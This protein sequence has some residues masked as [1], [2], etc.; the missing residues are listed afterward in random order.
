VGQLAKLH[1]QAALGEEMRHASDAMYFEYVDDVLEGGPL[2]VEGGSMAVPQEP[3]LGAA[4][5]EDA[6]ARWELTEARKRELDAYWRELKGVIGTSY[7]N[8][9][10]LVRHY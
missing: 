4:L 5:S 7:P 1:L 10:H 2:C 3:G 9:D 8:R 6:L